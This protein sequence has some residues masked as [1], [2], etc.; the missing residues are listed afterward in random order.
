LELSTQRDPPTSSRHDHRQP[1]LSDLNSK[2]WRLVG[3][4]NSTSHSLNGPSFPP[5][6]TLSPFRPLFTDILHLST[7]PASSS[8]PNP[9]LSQRRIRHHHSPFPQP[10]PPQTQEIPSLFPPQQTILIQGKLQI[11]NFTSSR[12]FLLFLLEKTSFVA[13]TRP[14]RPL[15]F[16]AEGL[17]SSDS[18]NDESSRTVVFTQGRSGKRHLRDRGCWRT[19]EDGSVGFDWNETESWEL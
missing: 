4:S 6:T 15:P 1:S 8:S 11:D 2:R 18:E 17:S 19:S 10:F 7:S 16:V 5:Q 3:F 12:K 9:A 13:S 14:S